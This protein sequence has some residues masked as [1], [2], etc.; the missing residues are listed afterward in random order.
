MACVHISVS[1]HRANMLNHKTRLCYT[2]FEE[3][4]E[5]TYFASP[6]KSSA[7]PESLSMILIDSSETPLDKL[8]TKFSFHSGS[9]PIPKSKTPYNHF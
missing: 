2:E 3:G 8:N 9:D 7:E 6:T 1:V 5:I 4:R